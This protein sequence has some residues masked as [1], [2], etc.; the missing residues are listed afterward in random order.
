MVTDKRSYNVFQYDEL[1]KDIGYPVASKVLKTVPKMW[2]P[3]PPNVR[4]FCFHGTLKPTPG[5]LKYPKGY[6]PDY[7]PVPNNVDGDGTVTHRSL[8]LCE[9]W[10]G[11]QKQEITYQTFTNAEHNGI[12]GDARFLRAFNK[13]LK[14]IGE[15]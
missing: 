9:E 15:H 6:F 4:M 14:S 10:V 5:N 2:Y 1:F 7:D 12:L 11:K 13:A 3:E 8:R